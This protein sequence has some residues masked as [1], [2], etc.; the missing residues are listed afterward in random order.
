MKR[1]GEKVSVFIPQESRDKK[2]NVTRHIV[3]LKTC[4]LCFDSEISNAVECMPQCADKN[5][6]WLDFM[7][8]SYHI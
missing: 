7:M 1:I 6:A 5:V 8:Y 4:S 3:F 2:Q